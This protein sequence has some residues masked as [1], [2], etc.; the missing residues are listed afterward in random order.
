MK[1]EFI[2]Q[3]KNLKKTYKKSTLL[4]NVSINVRKNTVY[5]LLGPN[6]AGKSTTLKIIAGMLKKTSGEIL[7]NGIYY[8][9]YPKQR[10]FLMGINLG[11]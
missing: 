10:T 2:L 7:F 11:F 5:A 4:D 3:I 9:D 8:Y 6:G 1:D